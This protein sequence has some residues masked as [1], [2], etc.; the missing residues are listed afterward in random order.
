[1]LPDPDCPVCKQRCWRYLAQRTYRQTDVPNLSAYATWR[2]KVLFKVWFPGRTEVQIRY[3]LCSVC[4]FLLYTPRPDQLDIDA[5]YRFLRSLEPDTRSADDALT[6][7][8]RSRQ[9]Y[10][11]VARLS[12]RKPN[13]TRILDYGGGDGRLMRVF[14]GMGCQCDVVDYSPAC[15]PGVRKRGDT[16][17]D[18]PAS[19]RYDWIIAS[20]VIEHVADPLGVVEALSR[21]LV[22]EGILYVEVPM[23]IWGRAPL[24]EEP[25]THVNFFTPTSLRY[26]LDRAGMHV[27]R[28]RLSAY[29]HPNGRQL[30]AVQAV[31]GR[32]HGQP[33][34]AAPGDGDA[35]RFL[36]PGLRER[37]WRY[38]LTPGNLLGAVQY[39][40]KGSLAAKAMTAR[41]PR[42]FS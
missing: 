6:E 27:Q 14:L 25:V 18:L 3:H 31:A 1:M 41:L 29:L 10:R 36:N 12:R 28:V 37:L 11:S 8:A 17:A 16:L 22:D 35:R 20:H 30:L 42:M 24:Q 4:G 5:K 26:L 21:H 33:T 15:I 19:E 34:P 32:G 39:K 40:V 2:Y 23:E 13:S 7:I 9:L 38:A